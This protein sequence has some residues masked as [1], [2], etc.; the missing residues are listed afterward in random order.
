VFEDGALLIG[1]GGELVLGRRLPQALEHASRHRRVEERLTIAD[2]ADAGDELGAADL[3]EEIAGCASHDG[4]EERFVV[5]E[6]GEHEA[7]DLGMA[8]PDL[9]A[10]LH[11]VAAVAKAHVEHGDLRPGRRDA[12]QRFVGGARLADDLEVVLALEELADP[13]AHDLVV[14]EEKHANCHAAILSD[15]AGAP[16]ASDVP[17]YA[18][19]KAMHRL[20]DAVLSV[21]SNLDI[22]TVL[23]QIVESAV[24][25]VDARYG[26]L[27]VLDDT[28]TGLAQ[29][30]TVGLDGE[31]RGRIGELP[32]GHGILGLLIVEP[33]PLR[34][35][36]LCEH[37]DSFGFPPNHPPMRSFLGVPVRVRDEV[38]G[39]LYLTDKTSAE[40]FTDVDEELVVALASAAGIAI[41]N[42]RLHER[43]R[44]L[45][46]LED[47]ERIARDLHDTVIQRLF[48]TGLGLEAS[49]RLAERSNP[50]VAQRLSTAVNDLDDTV[51]HIR[52]VIFG[53]ERTRLAPSGLRDDLLGV[54]RDAAGPLGF[55]PMITFDGAIDATVPRETGDELVAILREALTNV[56]RHAG[57]R[58]VQVA[59]RASGGMVDLSV[60]D[61]GCGFD[62]DSMRAGGH[63][64]ANLRARAD[65]V[66]GRA[67]VESTPGRGT[68]VTWSAP[69]GSS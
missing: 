10:H 33:H 1:Q 58:S 64:L 25:L 34:L 62:V 50:D 41:E 14:V 20:L 65:R 45:S 13:T 11:A 63:G 16:Y 12:S 44:D 23:R 61:D 56:A 46:V 18:G 49:A 9:A 35:P 59:V 32:K 6:A 22:T 28:K 47:R 26:A 37:P 29:F 53:L 67:G 31:A 39:N 52:T 17:D 8:R 36:D 7:G 43:V 21:S 2:P 3:L 66:H 55:E 38:F 57:A 5:G 40:V 68:R 51:R 30:I 19:P 60:V 15:S 4:A 69:L 42:A 27:G 48:A 24:D 54:A